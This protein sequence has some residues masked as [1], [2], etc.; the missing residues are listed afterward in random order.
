MALL[1]I[2]VLVVLFLGSLMI[3]TVRGFFAID[4][5][6]LGNV[7]LT[8]TA[9][10]DWLRLLV[11]IVIKSLLFFGDLQLDPPR[12]TSIRFRAKLI[13]AVVS[14]GLWDLA[15]RALTWALSN[16]FTNFEPVYGSLS[17][18][19]ALMTWMYLS[20]YIVFGARIWFMP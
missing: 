11:P 10:Y 14:A 16:G 18:I 6:H 8:E 3:D 5:I 9:L 20:G 15:T 7:Y 17:S 1:I 13:G 19:I 4:K 2:L 12:N